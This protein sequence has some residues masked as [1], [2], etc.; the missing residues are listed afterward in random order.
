MKLV[1]DFLNPLVFAGHAFVLAQMI[2]P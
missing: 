1:N 2:E